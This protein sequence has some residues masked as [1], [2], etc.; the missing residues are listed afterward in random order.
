[1]ELFRTCG[2]HHHPRTGVPV[3]RRPSR[4]LF[5]CRCIW[6]SASFCHFFPFGSSHVFH[7]SSINSRPT[8]ETPFLSSNTWKLSQP[9]DDDGLIFWTAHGR[10][11]AQTARRG[12][13]I[14]FGMYA[15]IIKVFVGVYA[16][17]WSKK[18]RSTVATGN[19]L[20]AIIIYDKSSSA[21]LR[22]YIHTYLIIYRF[23]GYLIYVDSFSSC[24][25]DD[26]NRSYMSGTDHSTIDR[27]LPNYFP[28]DLSLAGN[29]I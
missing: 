26:R 20:I 19:F 5:V 24:T 14:R 16:R 18:I 22:L 25:L 27:R 9:V 29:P 3:S 23:D 6:L 12:L 11:C 7:A 15:K 17:K 13:V 4:S 10:F 8:D 2:N 1:M 28:S 21:C